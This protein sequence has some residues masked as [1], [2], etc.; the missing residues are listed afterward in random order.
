MNVACSAEV[1][2]PVS[3]LALMAGR[4]KSGSASHSSQPMM[5]VS[6]ISLSLIEG[7]GRRRPPSGLN[8]VYRFAHVCAAAR[9]YKIQRHKIDDLRCNSPAAQSF[10]RA[11]GP[12]HAEPLTV[13]PQKNALCMP[14]EAG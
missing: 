13:W 8:P 2:A 10:D 12:D 6:T 7:S 9:R 11:G 5:N 3:I 14:F 4:P 1:R